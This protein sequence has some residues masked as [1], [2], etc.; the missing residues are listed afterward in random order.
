MSLLEYLV[1]QLSVLVVVAVAG[2]I[3]I[4]CHMDGE[5]MLDQI[6]RATHAEPVR[7]LLRRHRRLGP[8]WRFADANPYAV[9]PYGMWEPRQIPA[10]LIWP[11]GTQALKA[12]E[13]TE[14]WPVLE[15]AA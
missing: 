13:R 4:E 5:K 14:A 2:F 10:E 6:A 12:W 15:R 11:E 3:F 1:A 8:R 9:R 7:P